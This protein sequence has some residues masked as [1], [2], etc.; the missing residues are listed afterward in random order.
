MDNSTMLY[1]NKVFQQTTLGYTK[2]RVFLRSIGRLD[3]FDRNKT[4]TGGY[5]LVAF[6]NSVLEEGSKK[7][8]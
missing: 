5:S 4:S 1:T 3:E 2:A 7:N 8:A 6:A